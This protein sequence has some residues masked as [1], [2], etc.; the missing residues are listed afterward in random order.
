MAT[1]R[2]V[3]RGLR[4][5]RTQIFLSAGERQSRELIDKARQHCQALRIATSYHDERCFGGL[6][7]RQLSITLP[8]GVRIIG[9]PANPQTAR[10]LTGDVFLDEF[11]MHAFDRDVW[12]RR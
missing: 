12:A 8:G 9:L 5:R 2:R 6:S 4:R 10:G 3:L 1:L 11:A 7:I